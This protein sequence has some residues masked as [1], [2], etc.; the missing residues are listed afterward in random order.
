MSLS[1][2]MPFIGVRISCVAHDPRGS[3][4]A[5]LAL[6]ARRPARD[7]S[8]VR[9]WTSPSGPLDLGLDTGVHQTLE[10]ELTNQIRNLTLGS[11]LGRTGII[12]RGV[13]T[14]RDTG[15]C[16]DRPLIFPGTV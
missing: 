3:L 8:T 5:A 6:S 13:H 4:T 12:V 1:A 9:A 14:A 15:Q 16:N 10:H 7:S 11:D 2:R